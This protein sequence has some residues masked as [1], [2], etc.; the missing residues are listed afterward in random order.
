E[1]DYT[2]IA[3]S[4]DGKYLA[5]LNDNKTY[6]KVWD[7]QSME[8]II[9]EPLFDPNSND[10]CE[11]QDIYFSK[12][13]PDLIYYSGFFS[14]QISNK[15]QNGIFKYDI[16]IK[17]KERIIPD[18]L[19]DG[20]NMIFLNDGTKIFNTNGGVISVLNLL[21]NMLEYYAAPP[22][23]VYSAIVRY[24]TKGNF[25]I[26]AGESNKL[27]KFTYDGIT[28]IN[29]SY[30]EEITI[31][32]N[33]TGSFVNI[34]LNCTEP[35][36]NYQINNSEGLQLLQDTVN[37]NGSLQIDFSSYPVGVYFLTINCN[38]SP[39]TYKIIKEG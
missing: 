1:Y 20:L 33:P 29:Q 24:S 10:W 36:I 27:S 17:T 5:T 37:N 23:N 25:F 4:P 35:Q 8:Q 16:N 19:Y 6:L 34:S 12:I 13:N 38:N 15:R 31:S 3:V 2:A 14:K 21:E 32:P 28:N 7:L 30:D 39:K 9:N 26:G 11:A 22:K 18:G